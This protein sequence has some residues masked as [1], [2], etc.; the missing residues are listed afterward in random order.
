MNHSLCRE[1]IQHLDRDDGL[2]SGYAPE[3]IKN[4][5]EELGLPMDLLRLMQWDWPQADCHLGDIAINSSASL[6]ADEATAHLLKY[7]L[8][9]VGAHPMG[10]GLS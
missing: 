10:I 5:L 3:H 7:N 4:W 6:Y 1:F 8:L 9:N 2:K